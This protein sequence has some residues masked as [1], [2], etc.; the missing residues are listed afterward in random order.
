MDA[1]TREYFNLLRM[2][3]DN[4][5]T[6]ILRQPPIWKRL[7]IDSTYVYNMNAE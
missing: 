3:D 1:S 5:I 2:Q 7:Y 4:G 6:D